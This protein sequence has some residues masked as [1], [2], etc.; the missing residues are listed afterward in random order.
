MN[1]A[2]NNKEQY[3]SLLTQKFSDE[4]SREIIQFPIIEFP[5][6]LLKEDI[7]TACYTGISGSTLSDCDY[8]VDD[9]IVDKISSKSTLAPGNGLTFAVSFPKNIVAVLEP[10]EFVPFSETLLGRLV[11]W[12]L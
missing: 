2:T 11:S 5:G 12:L 1:S 9:R 3:L 4:L 8:L 7:K 6:K 10:E